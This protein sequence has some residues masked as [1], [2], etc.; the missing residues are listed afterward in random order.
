MYDLIKSTLSF[1]FLFFVI[2]VL[3]CVYAYFKFVAF[4]YWKKLGVPYDEPIVPFGS[5]N[6]NAF[7]KKITLGEF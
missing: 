5:I 6:V 3:L 7:L 1:P 2:F 4:S